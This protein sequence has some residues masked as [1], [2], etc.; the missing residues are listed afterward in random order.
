[1]DL[2]AWLA[3]GIFV[4]AIVT[5][6][7]GWID[8][9]LTALLGVALMVWVGV[10]TEDEAFLLVDWNVMAIL[11]SIWIIA[12][13]FGKSGVPEW[14]AIQALRLSGGHGG[15]LVMI[16]SLLSGLV[17]MVVD[18]VVVILMFA[19]VALPLVRHLGLPLTPVILM[20]GFS[21]NFMGSAMLLGD[22]PPQMLHSVSGAEFVDFIWHQGLPSSFPILLVTFLATLGG[23][24][25]Y[26]FR[27]YGVRTPQA[28]ASVSGNPRPVGAGT[29]A[30]ALDASARIPHLRFALTVVGMFVLTIV[31]MA[32][33]ELFGVK[34][35]FIAMSGA[36]LTVLVV[37]VLFRGR[38][39]P[40]FE[41][42]LAELDWRA[43]L[44]YIG[45][46]ALVG[47]V[48]KTGVLERLAH[49]LIPMFVANLALGAT[50]L[51]W[52]T[53]PIVGI[54]EHD[55][56]ILTFLY[57]IRD[58]GQQGVDPW[59]LWWMLLWAGTLGSNL[60]VAGAPAL[61]VALNIC[62]REEK[63]TIS[64]GTFLRWSV[65]FVVLSTIICYAI[66]MA[67]WVLPRA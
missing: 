15:L 59:P 25:L 6:I 56:Y 43:I 28:A 3:L 53:V 52:V 45:L 10:V 47:A 40:E 21:A 31:A 61:Y 30:N 38:E 17:S 4:A 62:E 60:T 5:V 46:F 58:L 27:T 14:L 67:I 48:E 66:G 50:L 26:G 63:M 51:Y 20:I 24:Y 65:P 8:R 64:V 11:I 35:G 49:V 23:M 13:Y 2:T 16:L 32:L 19:P 33:R 1:M 22:L 34:L 44:F 57:T 55:A 7:G 39:R 41:A 54:V 9:A 29:A 37:E 42:I 36:V 12:G 18:N